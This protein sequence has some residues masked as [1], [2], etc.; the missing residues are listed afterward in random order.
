[1]QSSVNRHRWSYDKAAGLLVAMA[2][3]LACREEKQDGIGFIDKYKNKYPRHTAFK[4]KI[5]C[6][7]QGRM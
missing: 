2:E 7:V 4:R 5:T 1:M 6:A 3:T